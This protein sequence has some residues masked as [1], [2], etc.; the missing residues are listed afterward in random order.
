M[1]RKSRKN[2]GG[3]NN[4]NT[5]KSYKVGIYAR[6]SI[7]E[8]KNSIENQISI[9]KRFVEDGNCE[10]EEFEIVREFVDNGFTGTDFERY[11]FQEMIKS[12]K[13]KEIDCII[14]KDF[15]RFGRN[16]LEVSDYIQNV[17]PF[18]GVRFI[19]INDNYDSFSADASS[20]IVMNIINL[21][22]E[23]YA[24]DIS[25]KI[26]SSI[27][28]K[29][30]NGDFIGNYATYGYK[31]DAQNKNMLVVDCYACEI[32]R[33]IFKMKAGGFSHMK[34]V[35][36]LRE[37]KILTPLNYRKNLVASDENSKWNRRT[38]INI[39]TN[40]TYL[41]DLVQGRKFQSLLLGQKQILLPK[42]KW[43][44]VRNTHEA[45]ISRELFCEVQEIMKMRK[46]EYMRKISENA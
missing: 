29:R 34:I 11:E 14:V 19:S 22:N 8:N 1:A 4:T 5:K 10:N 6:L 35:N 33:K 12:V 42:E 41:G 38:I 39:L 17:F 27:N 46:D 28:A 37:N 44:V 24:K 40:E 31:K 2:T 20:E 21:V 9:L 23:I 26:S 25:A 32:V 3:N 30:K 36:N 16:S 7:A 15:S 13:N 43:V 18:L 45:I